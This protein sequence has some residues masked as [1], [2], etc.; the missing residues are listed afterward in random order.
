MED[1]LEPRNSGEFMN[2]GMTTVAVKFNDGGNLW[3]FKAP[4]DLV[5]KMAPNKTHVLCDTRRGISLGR[6]VAIHKTPNMEVMRNNCIQYKWVFA[7][8]DDIDLERLEDLKREDAVYA[9]RM[10]CLLKCSK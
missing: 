9:K 6:V 4:L 2:P 1:K 7:I 8:V 3:T 5:A 10:E